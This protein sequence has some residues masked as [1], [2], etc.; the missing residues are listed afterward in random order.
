M[1]HVRRDIH[2]I[3]QEAWEIVKPYFTELIAHFVIF[4][5]TM[6]VLVLMLA[7]SYEVICFCEW[8]FHEDPLILKGL[9]YTS[10]LL[11][12]AHFVWYLSPIRSKNFQL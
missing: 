3:I 7:I 9:V 5:L 1:D 12:T 2:Q 8:T 4:C 11:I 6:L 10:D